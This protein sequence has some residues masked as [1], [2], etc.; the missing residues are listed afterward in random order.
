MA[1]ASE[2]TSESESVPIPQPE[3]PTPPSPHESTP[4]DGDV[5]LE[6]VV[7]ASPAETT[8]SGA[9]PENPTPSGSTEDDEERHLQTTANGDPHFKTWKNEHFEFH[10]QCDLVMVSNKDFADGLGI[11]IH[12]RTKIVRFWSYIQSVA[13][14]IG[15]DILEV[16]GSVN[17]EEKG[18][19]KL[20]YW[21]NHEYKGDL[22]DLAGFPINIGFKHDKYFIDLDSVYPGQK[23][24]I[25]TFKEFVSIKIIGATES[26]FGNSVGITGDYKSGKTLSRDG[27]T[28]INDF[29]DLGMEWQV[30][31]S[32]GKLFHDSSH[33]QF[34]E[35]CLLPED[36]RGERTRRL[37]ESSI[38]EEQAEA[39]CAGLKDE[40]DRKDCIYDIIATQDMDMAGAY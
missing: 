35:L 40:L 3:D 39:A 10:G 8:T 19:A 15:N 7:A 9:K 4:T 32:D 34:P 26:S 22:E 13:I 12:I 16:Q 37:S 1:A 21:S 17:N 6:T 18:N 11:D 5:R 14:R 2:P 33:P 20:H 38:T 29:N 23:I 27:A 31:P 36:P 25:G 24:R 30:L 28:E